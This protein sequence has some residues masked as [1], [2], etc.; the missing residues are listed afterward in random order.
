MSGATLFGIIRAL[1]RLSQYAGQIAY[2]LLT[3]SPLSLRTARLACIR[4]AT[5]VRSEPGSNSSLIFKVLVLLITF[6]LTPRIDSWSVTKHISDSFNLPGGRSGLRPLPFGLSAVPFEG[7]ANYRIFWDNVKG[8]SQ[9][10]SIFFHFFEK[11]RKNQNI[12]SLKTQ[13]QQIIH[14]SESTKR[15]H[16]AFTP[17][18]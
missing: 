10:N 1:A 7:E 11:T 15:A 3:R 6:V 2:A 5:S 9:K 17:L 16:R 4:H 13:Y 12:S 18:H 14:T 8:F